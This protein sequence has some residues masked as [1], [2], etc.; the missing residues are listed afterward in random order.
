[1]IENDVRKS[2]KYIATDI[3]VLEFFFYIRQ[4]VHENICYLSYTKRKGQI[5]RQAVKDKTK[6]RIEKLFDKLKHTL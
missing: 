5:L 6:D 2:I 4:V 3:G 1:M